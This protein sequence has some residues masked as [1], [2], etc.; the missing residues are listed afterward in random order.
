MAPERITFLSLKAVSRSHLFDAARALNGPDE[1]RG[2]ALVVAQSAVEVGIETAID[3]ALQLRE[4][5]D[6]LREWVNK[7]ATSW[8]P[9]NERV[10]GLWTALTGDEI[11]RAPGWAAYKEGIKRR[12]AFVHRA[13]AVSREDADRFI[14]SAEQVIDHVVEVMTRVFGS[15]TS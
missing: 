1:P 12:H 7:T 8:S 9:T 3:F 11:T 2:P 13:A 4:V 5:D 10:Q 15:P 6:P 14:A